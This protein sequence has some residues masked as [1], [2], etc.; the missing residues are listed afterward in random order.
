MRLDYFIT[1][2]NLVRK[3]SKMVIYKEMGEKVESDHDAIG[4]I[5]KK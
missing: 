3:I 4:L 5:L 2:K 1:S